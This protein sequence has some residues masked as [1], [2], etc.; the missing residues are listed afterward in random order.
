M[1]RQVKMAEDLKKIKEQKES[2]MREILNK[3]DLTEFE[4]DLLMNDLI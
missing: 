3:K 4:L 2:K 1:T